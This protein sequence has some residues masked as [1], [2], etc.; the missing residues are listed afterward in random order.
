MANRGLIA[1][2]RR[3]PGVV[4]WRNHQMAFLRLAAR[5]PRDLYV[6]LRW[7]R[8]S[9][10]RKCMEKIS[11]SLTSAAGQFSKTVYC[12]RLHQPNLK[13]GSICHLAVL[14]GDRTH[15][16]ACSGKFSTRACMSLNL[17]DG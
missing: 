4:V 15:M 13:L 10:F 12:N 3:L 7:A 17:H 1:A 14:P 6:V 16:E 9:T 8:P 2:V 11:G 5:E